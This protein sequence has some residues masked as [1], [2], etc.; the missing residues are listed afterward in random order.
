MKFRIYD[1]E[2]RISRR[3]PPGLGES[4]GSGV[5]RDDFIQNG[6][7]FKTHRRDLGRKSSILSIEHNPRTHVSAPDNST[8]GHSWSPVRA[9]KGFS[10]VDG[11]MI[12]VR[13]GWAKEKS[14]I[15]NPKSEIGGS[16]CA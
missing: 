1:F 16:R 7:R 12:P 13:K 4:S 11:D 6:K 9:T 10:D 15:R 5:R 2:L 14:E 3:P 8:P